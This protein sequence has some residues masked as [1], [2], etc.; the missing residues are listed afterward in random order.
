MRPHL[1]SRVLVHLVF[2]RKATVSCVMYV[3]VC[4]R[5]EQL[6]SCMMDFHEIWYLSVSAK[7]VLAF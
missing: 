3:C 4:V 5:T 6:G 1:L 7:C 2:R